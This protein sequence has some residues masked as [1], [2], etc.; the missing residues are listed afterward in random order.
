MIATEHQML[1]ALDKYG[2]EPGY[3]QALHSLDPDATV[4]KLVKAH[5]A[6]DNPRV[7]GYIDRVRKDGSRALVQARMEGIQT[8]Y[9]KSV[10]YEK[11]LRD[12]RPTF[13]QGAVVKTIDSPS[14][15]PVVMSA[16]QM[17]QMMAQ[18]LANACP[19]FSGVAK[20]AR[21]TLGY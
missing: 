20:I 14:G 11:M 16:Y 10:E 7:R 17:V 15:F 19:T 9:A 5:V 2:P 21:G 18:D 4:A 12:S 13:A 8:I 1:A 6:Q 3:E